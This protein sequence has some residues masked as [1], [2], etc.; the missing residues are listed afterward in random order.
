M[1]NQI[2]RT[3]FYLGHFGPTRENFIALPE[4]WEELRFCRDHE[5]LVNI[6]N[7]IYLRTRHL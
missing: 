3:S 4:D 2:I 7:I 1:N 5:V 6:P